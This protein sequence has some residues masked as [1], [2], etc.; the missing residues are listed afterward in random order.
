MPD[1]YITD[2]FIA[3]S[4]LPEATYGTALLTAANYFSVV[5]RA[6]LL[7]LPSNRKSDDL[8]VIGRGSGSMYPSKQSSDLMNPIGFEMQDR[9]NVGSFATLLRRY[10]GHPQVSGDITV[11]E[12]A[13]AWKHTFFEQDPDVDAGGR[14][15]PSSSVVYRN[16]G[17]DF[18]HPGCVG[19]TLTVSQTGATKPD[20]TMAFNNGGFYHRI[21]EI[22]APVF[23]SLGLPAAE[24]E[25]HGPDSRVL[26]TDTGGTRNLVVP[27]RRLKSIS[28][29]ANNNL[30]LADERAGLPSMDGSGCPKKGW[31]RDFLLFG[32][33]Q[34]S[35]TY[36][37]M[38]D[39]TMREWKQAVEDDVIT[40]FTWNML[41]NCVPTTA[42]TSRYG[43]NLIISKCQF[44]DPAG[45]EDAN[46]AVADIVVFPEIQATHY[47]V[48][49]FEVVNGKS[50]IHT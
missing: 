37:V 20:Y 17:A 8:G 49:K 33:R 14:Q 44:R 36:R 16:K 11:V 13:K 27:D 24:E 5:T 35:A 6:R 26:Y 23:G 15:L 10:M 25:M 19:A 45:N 32:D 9:V 3:F 47:G 2:T 41:G 34:I 40:S 7:P 28:F 22:T 4:L 30:D 12:A 1:S 43:V 31:Y 46:K 18:L 39:A 21:G 50:T 48:Y 42:T 38:V 29:S